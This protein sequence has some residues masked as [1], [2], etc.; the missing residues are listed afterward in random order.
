MYSPIIN[1]VWKTKYYLC[2]CQN[3]ALPVSNKRHGTH[4]VYSRN[5]SS[6]C[7]NI[8]VSILWKSSLS[9][10]YL[11]RLLGSAVSIPLYTSQHFQPFSALQMLL[12]IHF[13]SIIHVRLSLYNILFTRSHSLCNVR[14]RALCNGAKYLVY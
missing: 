11:A 13:T 8:S 9:L 1:N 12:R 6:I 5:S 7:N 4:L 3:D 2:S 14:T 10:V